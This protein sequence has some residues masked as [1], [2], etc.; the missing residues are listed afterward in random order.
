MVFGWLAHLIGNKE[1]PVNTQ[2]HEGGNPKGWKKCK[3]KN[4]KVQRTD[5]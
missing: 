2:L 5:H 3:D 1:K 4:N